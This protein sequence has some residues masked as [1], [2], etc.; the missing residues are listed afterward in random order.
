MKKSAIFERDFDAT[1]DG[2]LIVNCYL[3]D[4][5]FQVQIDSNLDYALNYCKALFEKGIATN[6]YIRPT[7]WDGLI[8]LGGYGVT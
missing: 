7:D 3:G 8:H 5:T 2:Q 1:L 4:L 6:L